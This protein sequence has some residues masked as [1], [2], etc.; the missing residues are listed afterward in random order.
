MKRL[1]I[2]SYK[3]MLPS[4]AVLEQSLSDDS[5]YSYNDILHI[6]RAAGA[7]YI[8]ICGVD[9]NMPPNKDYWYITL[10]QSLF[11]GDGRLLNMS[12]FAKK[13]DPASGNIQAAGES[14]MLARAE[15][16]QQLPFIVTEYKMTLSAFG[17]KDNGTE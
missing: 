2:D 3:M 7:E 9:G 13:V 4:Y 11:T 15:L 14:I 1:L 10:N 8:I 6:S 12:S 17:G 16:Q 5:K